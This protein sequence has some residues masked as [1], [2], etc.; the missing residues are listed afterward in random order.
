MS[1]SS[2]LPGVRAFRAALRGSRQRAEGRRQN[3]DTPIVMVGVSLSCVWTGLSAF[4][5]LPSALFLYWLGAT[6]SCCIKPSMSICTQFSTALPSL[7]R[8]MSL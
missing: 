3:R 8:Q 7:K 1:A 5:P 4:C 6:P 2:A